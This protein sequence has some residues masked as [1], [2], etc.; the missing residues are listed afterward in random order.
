M[1]ILKNEKC[2]IEYDEEKKEI[3]GR[4]LTDGYNDPAFYNKTVRGIKK[5][6]QQVTEQ[7]T[8]QTTMRDVMRIISSNNIKTHYW[9]MVD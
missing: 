1:S 3:F 4:D 7:F 2:M 8:E 6:W 9:C 5:A